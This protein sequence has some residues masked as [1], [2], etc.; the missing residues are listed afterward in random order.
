MTT[1]HRHHDALLR[2]FTDLRDRTHGDSP[3]APQHTRAGKERLFREAVALLDSYAH[4][5]LAGLN[6]EL[7]LHT[8]DIAATGVQVATR[9]GLEAHWDLTWPEQRTTRLA[10][11]RLTAVYAAGF[12]HPHLQGGTVGQWPLNVFTD[13]QAAAELPILRAI[14]AA[15]LHNLVFQ[16]DHRIIPAVHRSACGGA[17]RAVRIRDTCPQG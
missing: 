10:P 8:G 1:T 16:G 2:H 6:A 9:G 11:V 4:T 15:D 17:A 7:L 13:A 5:A 14:A 3:A 12:H